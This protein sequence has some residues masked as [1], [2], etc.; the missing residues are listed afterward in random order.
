LALQVALRYRN[1]L[2]VE[3]TFETVKALLTTRPFFHKT[4]AAIRGHD[5]CSFLAALLRKDLLDRLAWRLTAI[6]NGSTSLMVSRTSAKLKLSK[7]G[8]VLCHG[9]VPR[10]HNRSHLPC[11]RDHL[12]ARLPGDATRP[13]SVLICGA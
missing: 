1:L 9:L 13:T 8:A 11:S 12:A 3:D 7:K 2:A 4:D 10:P 5:F 6:S